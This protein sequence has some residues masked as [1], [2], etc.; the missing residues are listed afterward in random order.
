MFGVPPAIIG[1]LQKMGE[2]LQAAI[3]RATQDVAKGLRPNP[4]ELA[5][6]LHSEMES[7][8]P[9]MKKRRL[10]DPETRKAAAR[11]LAGVACNLVSPAS[12]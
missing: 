9:E 10:A 12:P 6:W 5:D 1:M 8:E 3:V 4:D 7:W 11:F 2:F